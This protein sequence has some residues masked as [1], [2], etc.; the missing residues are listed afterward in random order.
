MSVKLKAWDADFFQLKV[1]ECK[2]D[3][4]ENRFIDTF[5]FDLIYLTSSSK[6][7]VNLLHYENTFSAI[8]IVFEKEITS[9]KLYPPN[10]FHFN[11]LEGCDR[12]KLYELAF[13]S[14]KYSRFKLDKRFSKKN[15]HDLYIKWV[16][17]SIDGELADLILL[18]MDNKEIL[19]F[20]TCS[21][22]KDIAVIGLLAVT[23]KAQGKGIGGELVRYLE[24]YL[25]VQGI[26][27]ISVATQ[28]QNFLAVKFYK[29][30]GFKLA[31]L[32]YIK[33]FWKL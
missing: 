2:V 18:Y 23:I 28:S 20:I 33:H 17:N 25:L 27:Q 30:I 15:F 5:D 26:S 6:I 21:I 3:P 29:K 7:D 13:E 9:N 12:N 11:Q 24:T 4:T 1:G 31:S 32:K 16:D 10:I 19:G 8:Q 14:G 22:K